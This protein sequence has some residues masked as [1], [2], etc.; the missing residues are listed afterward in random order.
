M[1]FLKKLYAMIKFMAIAWVSIYAVVLLMYGIFIFGKAS[2]PVTYAEVE[3]PVFVESTSTAPVLERIAY[4]ES[5]GKQLNKDGQVLI[6]TNTNGTYDTGEFQINS[7]W[8]QTATKMGLDL[9]KQA[10]NE[11]FAKWLY[12][13]KGTEDWYSSKG[14]WS[15]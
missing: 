6:K 11:K 14:C 2:A 7:V 8:N 5:G 1:K 12:E 4:C 10:D 15:K 13:N 9:T 3:V